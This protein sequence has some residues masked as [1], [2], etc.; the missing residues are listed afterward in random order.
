VQGTYALESVTDEPSPLAGTVVLTAD[1][2]AV[3]RVRYVSPSSADTVEFTDR[4]SFRLSGDGTLDLELHEDDGR[5]PDIWR[6]RATLSNNVI[7]LRYPNAS[8]GPD[9][10]ESYRRQ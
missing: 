8:D 7:V 9:N 4:G 6:P 3:R 1:G 10:I 5:S 2:R